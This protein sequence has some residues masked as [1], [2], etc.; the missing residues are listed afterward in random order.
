[1]GTAYVYVKMTVKLLLS[2]TYCSVICSSEVYINHKTCLSPLHHC[3]V[4]KATRLRDS[5]ARGIKLHSYSCKEGKEKCL[6]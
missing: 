3:D 4:D 1:M 6:E 2:L 5:V